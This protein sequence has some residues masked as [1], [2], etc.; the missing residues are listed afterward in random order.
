[1]SYNKAKEI[2]RSENINQLLTI[3]YLVSKGLTYTEIGNR[4]GV[5]RQAVSSMIKNHNKGFKIR[6]VGSNSKNKTRS[7]IRLNLL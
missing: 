3:L 1:M 5:S 6:K 7:T 2:R 4:L